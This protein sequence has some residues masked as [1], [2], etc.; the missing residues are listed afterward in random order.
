[1]VT[2]LKSLE[3]AAAPLISFLQNASMVQEL[4]SDKQ[5]NLLMLSE[6]YQV[7]FLQIQISLSPADFHDIFNSLIS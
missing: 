4:R 7:I 5:Y 2:R 3:D 6:K 1:M